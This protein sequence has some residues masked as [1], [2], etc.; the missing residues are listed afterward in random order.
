MPLVAKRVDTCEGSAIAQCWEREKAARASSLTWSTRTPGPYASSPRSDD[1]ALP[2]S[3]LSYSTPA[4]ARYPRDN[5]KGKGLPRS[6]LRREPHRSFHR[7]RSYAR[8]TG[9]RIAVVAEHVVSDRL[10]VA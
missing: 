5:R 7:L 8:N 10:N 1:L 6:Q 2:R 3:A 4:G 9:V